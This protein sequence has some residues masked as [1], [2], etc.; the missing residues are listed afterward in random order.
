V[1][2][3]YGIMPVQCIMLFMTTKVMPDCY[4][5]PLLKVIVQKD[6]SSRHNVMQINRTNLFP[7]FSIT[8]RAVILKMM[9]IS[10]A[11]LKV[12]V[13]SFVSVVLLCELVLEWRQL[14]KQC[15]QGAKQLSMI[16]WSS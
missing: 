7:S 14:Q 12:V 8:S 11:H 6:L 13:A 15:H 16:F 4:T 1:I 3:L 2:C 5:E 10:A 9:P